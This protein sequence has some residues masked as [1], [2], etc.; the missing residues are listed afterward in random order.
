MRA[1]VDNSDPNELVE[2]LCMIVVPL[3]HLRVLLINSPMGDS[4]LDPT[5]HPLDDSS[6]YVGLEHDLIQPHS[7][8]VARGLDGIRAGRS[9]EDVH[10]SIGGWCS[11][12]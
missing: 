8:Q 10:G 12:R 1:T 9:P 4:S 6:Q 3:D 5:A 2:P 11:K 7:S